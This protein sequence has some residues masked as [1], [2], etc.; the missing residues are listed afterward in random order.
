MK[1]VIYAGSLRL[2]SSTTMQDE[3]TSFMLSKAENGQGKSADD[4]ND[5]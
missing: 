3:S 5:I 4:Y 2:P 1:N